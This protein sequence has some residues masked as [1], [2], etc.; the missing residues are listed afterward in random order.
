MSENES[1]VSGTTIVLVSIVTAELL[2]VTD[3]YSVLA[4]PASSSESEAEGIW[5]ADASLFAASFLFA[6]FFCAFDKGLLGTTLLTA[7]NTV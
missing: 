6:A 5:A 1:S 4:A 7:C 2:A 3:A